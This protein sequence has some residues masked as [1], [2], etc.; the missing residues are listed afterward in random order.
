MYVVTWNRAP[1]NKK[2]GLE[3]KLWATGTGDIAFILLT[4]VTINYF[5]D[6]SFVSL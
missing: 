2:G 1:S 6:S 3:N 4:I 5:L